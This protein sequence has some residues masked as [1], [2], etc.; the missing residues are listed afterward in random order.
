MNELIINNTTVVFKQQE[1][2]IFTD[3]LTIAKVFGKEHKHVMESI[4]NSG[5]LEDSEYSRKFDPTTYKA[6]NGK[7]NK[8]Y[9]LDRDAFS[10]IIMGF[11]GKEAL[12]WKMDYIKAFN[13]MEKELLKPAVKLTPIQLMEQ[14]NLLLIEENKEKTKLLE[15]NKKIIDS[16]NIISKATSDNGTTLTIQ[17]FCKIVTDVIDGTSL[18]RTSA[19]AVLRSMKLVMAKSTQPTQ[20]AMTRRLLNYI[21][22]D[23][24]YMTVVYNDRANDLIKLMVKHL[25]DNFGLNEALGGL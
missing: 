11:T 6:S 23:Y 2:S 3:S 5:L 19:Y 8:M 25:Q 1:D 13:A 22:H 4:K 10:L 18:G 21:K 20:S 16:M 7:S 12:R 17:E 9:L 24:G 14:A 15:R